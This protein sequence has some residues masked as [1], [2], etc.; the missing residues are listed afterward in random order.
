MQVAESFPKLIKKPWN[1]IEEEQEKNMYPRKLNWYRACTAKPS[2][3]M[4]SLYIHNWNKTLEK[5]QSG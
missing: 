3:R 4:C 5:K 1:C 2:K